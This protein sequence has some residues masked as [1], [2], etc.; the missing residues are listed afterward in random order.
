LK[1]ASSAATCR[2]SASGA[3]AV[4]RGAPREGETDAEVLMVLSFHRHF[5]DHSLEFE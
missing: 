5:G 1:L 3:A 2:R 4:G